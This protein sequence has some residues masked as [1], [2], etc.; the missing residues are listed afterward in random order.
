M[1]SVNSFKSAAQ[2]HHSQTGT[3]HK[4]KWT[5]QS[6]QNLSTT[7]LQSAQPHWVRTCWLWMRTSS[8]WRSRTLLAWW[9]QATSLLAIRIRGWLLSSWLSKRADKVIVSRLMGLARGKAHLR[10]KRESRKGKTKTQTNSRRNPSKMKTCS[11]FRIRLEIAQLKLLTTITVQTLFKLRLI[12][13]RKSASFR[14][15]KHHQS[16][17]AKVLWPISELVRLQITSHNNLR[18]ICLKI[19]KTRDNQLN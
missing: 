1:T 10:G 11:I 13:L 8:E 19:K 14:M 16:S 12:S 9:R 3:S 18:T 5:K 7:R 2:G 6:V 4:N 15:V 17:P